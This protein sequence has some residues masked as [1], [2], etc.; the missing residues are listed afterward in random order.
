[1]SQI[2]EFHFNP[3]PKDDLI[4]DSFCFEP[5]NVYEKRM[6]SLYMVGMLKNALPQNVRFLDNISQTI[7]GKYYK[8]VS[9]MLSIW[10]ARFEGKVE[11]MPMRGLI[12]SQASL[13]RVLA[14]SFTWGAF[15]ESMR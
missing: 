15:S 3:K 2:L 1:M 14:L 5:S 10:L 11:A 12:S 6:G 8:T 7:K 4:F 9:L 13:K